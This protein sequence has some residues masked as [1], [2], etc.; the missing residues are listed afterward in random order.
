MKTYYVRNRQ[1]AYS[2]IDANYPTYAIRNTEADCDCGTSEAIE[3]E[4]PNGET[5]V[6]YI[7]CEECLYNAPYSERLDDY[8]RGFT[9]ADL[10]NTVA[11]SNSDPF[12]VDD[13]RMWQD[14]A[15]EVADNYLEVYKLADVQDD[16]D[17]MEEYVD[18]A[19]LLDFDEN[20]LPEAIYK[21]G[22]FTFAWC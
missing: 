6:R 3:V 22:V 15:D 14:L 11:I 4:N 17:D 7:V 9:P 12:N 1:E 13:A 2:H 19:H 20:N 5:E 8:K 16:E 21:A 10:H 18:M